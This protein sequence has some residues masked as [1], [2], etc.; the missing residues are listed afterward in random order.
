M[1]FPCEYF[2][3]S[4]PAQANATFSVGRKISETQFF[5]ET[6]VELQGLLRLWKDGGVGL[7]QELMV[8]LD[9]VMIS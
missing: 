1:S 4:S 5:V 8:T 7:S 3:L 2:L 9:H 6:V